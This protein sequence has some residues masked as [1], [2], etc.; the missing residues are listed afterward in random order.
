MS[1][2]NSALQSSPLFRFAIN[3]GPWIVL[4]C[5]AFNVRF[6]GVFCIGKKGYLKCVCDY[7]SMTC[8]NN[9]IRIMLG[10]K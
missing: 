7:C 5:T 4:Y 6:L 10:C 8:S 3:H 1:L 2:C 9:I